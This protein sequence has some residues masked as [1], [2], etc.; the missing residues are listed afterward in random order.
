MANPDQKPLLQHPIIRPPEEY[1]VPM[2]PVRVDEALG[3]TEDLDR[4]P[5]GVPHAVIG[6]TAGFSLML[7]LLVGLMFIAG[8]T[9]SRVAAIVL[10]LLAVPTL[11][12]VLRKRADRD[13]DHLHP[14]R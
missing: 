14:S 4:Q 1:E 3:P 5:D 2:S 6:M 10:V 12:S 9:F 8:N 7:A 13:R 11:V